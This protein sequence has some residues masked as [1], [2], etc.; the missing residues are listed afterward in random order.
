MSQI[1]VPK[2]ASVHALRLAERGVTYV[3]VQWVD[4]VNTVRFRILPVSYFTRLCE[5]ARPGVGLSHVTLG[6]VGLNAAEGFN[7]TGEHLYVID[8]NS[9]RLCPYAPGQA[10]V[11][12]WF[13]EKAPLPNGSLANPLCP[14]TLLKRIVDEAQAKAG[15][16][17]L[18]GF[19][20]EFI[21]LSAISPKPVTVVDG[22][23]S[24]TV[25]NTVLM[26]IADDLQEAGLELQMIHA[27]SAPG[28]FEVVTGP[29]SP[30]E[31]ADAVVHTRETI[32][33][34]ASK[35]GLRATFAPRLHADN[36]GNGAHL[37]FSVHSSK[38]PATGAR[39]DAALAPTLTATERSFLQGILEQLPSLCAFTLPTSASYARMVDGI[40]AGGTYSCWGM[41]NKD[42]PIRL[43]GTQGAHHFEMKTADGTS[44][45]YLVLASTL[46]AG[47][48]GVLSGAVLTSGDCAKPVAFM[49]DAER[50]AVGLENP[51]RLPRT[52][53]DARQLLQGDQYLREKLGEEFVTKYAAVNKLLEQYM[54]LPSEEETI[55]RLVE[56]Y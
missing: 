41:D 23:W 20:S 9:F 49:S 13:Q 12:G 6:L 33:N 32:Y 54:R 30:L 14:R 10:V 8:L 31:A 4:L 18:A 7:G 22:D 53:G 24:C 47:L 16:S 34:V 56:Y 55:T 40:W 27:E 48:R 3:R 26:E 28:Q 17:F 35:H 45:P 15:L 37:H 36:C 43:C 21:L 29:L 2:Y 50:K 42:A 38:P 44:N 19:E 11:M 5:T 39:P 46:A 25:G 51:L 1:G 52:V